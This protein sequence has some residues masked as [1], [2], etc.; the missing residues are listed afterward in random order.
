MT[1]KTNINLYIERKRSTRLSLKNSKSPVRFTKID[2][3]V[4]GNLFLRTNEK[5]GEDATKERMKELQELKIIGEVL[6]R[7]LVES[8]YDT[9]A[10]DEEGQS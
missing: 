1:E 8:I 2:V 6:S 10:K 7:R 5:L 9:I 3:V 4:D